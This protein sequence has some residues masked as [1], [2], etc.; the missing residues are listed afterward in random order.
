MF[1]NGEGLQSGIDN[2]E[3]VKLEDLK[4]QISKFIM[5]VFPR[6]SSFVICC[7]DALFFPSLFKSLLHPKLISFYM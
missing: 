2:L 6:F 3:K 5:K 4:D 1:S 7:L